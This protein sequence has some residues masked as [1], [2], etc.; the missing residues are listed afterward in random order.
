MNKSN[1]CPPSMNVGE[2][3]GKSMDVRKTNTNP[4]QKQWSMKSN[5]T[6]N[7]K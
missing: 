5:P 7:K 3:K 2:C 6:S 4:S 1:Q